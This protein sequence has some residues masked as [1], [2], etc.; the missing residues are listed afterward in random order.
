MQEKYEEKIK[1]LKEFNS[2]N[3]DLYKKIQDL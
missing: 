3:E 2:S 1:K